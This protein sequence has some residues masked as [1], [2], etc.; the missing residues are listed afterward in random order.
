M[1]IPQSLNNFQSVILLLYMQI[2]LSFFCLFFINKNILPLQSELV[3][4]AIH[5]ANKSEENMAIE[6]EGRNLFHSSALIRFFWHRLS[7]W[8]RKSDHFQQSQFQGHPLQ[9]N[10]RKTFNVKIYHKSV[11]ILLSLSHCLSSCIA[12]SLLMY[13]Q[14][15]ILKKSNSILSFLSLR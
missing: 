4:C 12:S 3:T 15:R 5:T 9:T 7:H 6:E 10:L 2:I 8:F 14:A 13:Y 1:S 11:N